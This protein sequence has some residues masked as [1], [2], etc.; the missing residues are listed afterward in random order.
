MNREALLET[1]KAEFSRA[2][3][4]TERQPWDRYSAS[5]G[6][7]VYSGAAGQTAEDVLSLAD[8]DM[9]RRKRQCKDENAPQ[10]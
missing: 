10:A 8:E 1:A 5:V 9:Y 6:L 4:D 2:R 3:S 7:A